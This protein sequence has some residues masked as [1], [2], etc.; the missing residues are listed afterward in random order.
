[1]QYLFTSER[2]GFRN[3]IDQDL[4]SFTQMNQDPVVMEFFPNILNGEETKA[5]IDR[6][7]KTY[8]DIGYT[9][10]AVCTLDNNEFIGFIGMIESTF[11]A[12]FTP[13]KEI[14]WR[15]KTSA[16][17]KGFATEGAKRCL[18][19]G[20]ETLG[21]KSI[22]SITPLTNQK[23]EKIMHKIG[24]KK[25]TEFEHPKIE[26]KHELSIHSAYCIK[27][28]DWINLYS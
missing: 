13:C 25:I 20:F 7:I 15:L 1:M 5:M 10:Y 4:H 28:E 24:M 22:Y 18:K 19:Y 3:W 23:S 26:S 9:F 17:G 16:W 6:M 12:P 21:F 2:L 14:G 8:Q 27:K 11:K